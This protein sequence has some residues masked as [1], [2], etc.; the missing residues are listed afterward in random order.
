M[1]I[2]IWGIL[3]L[4]Q[5]AVSPSPWPSK[6]PRT[7]NQRRTA[8]RPE[9]SERAERSGLED[10][11]HGQHRGFGWYVDMYIYIYIIYVWLYIFG[12]R[13]RESVLCIGSALTDG[14]NEFLRWE[15]ASLQCDQLPSSLWCLFSERSGN[16]LLWKYSI[17]VPIICTELEGKGK[18]DP[19][20]AFPVPAP[21][22]CVSCFLRK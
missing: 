18:F 6:L 13:E 20:E 10:D 17:P 22:F 8:G 2:W 21:A 12:D 14:I 11:T 16:S 9:N 7:S 5:W 4:R 3:S 1:A 19:C 15:V